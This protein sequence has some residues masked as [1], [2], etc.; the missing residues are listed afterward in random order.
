MPPNLSVVV[1]SSQTCKVTALC[2]GKTD[3]SCGPYHGIRT[4]LVHPTANKMMH[5]P[6]VGLK[7]DSRDGEAGLLCGGHKK[8]SNHTKTGKESRISRYGHL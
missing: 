5:D 3:S 8:C 4:I 6:A 1:E 2:N 7:N